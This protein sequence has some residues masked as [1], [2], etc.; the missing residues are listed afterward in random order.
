MQ[1]TRRLLSSFLLLM[2]L[3]GTFA[4]PGEWAVAGASTAGSARAQAGLSGHF[5]ALFANPAGLARL[6]QTTMGT[7]LE[8]RFA[9]AELSAA[10]AGAFGHLAV[11][12]SDRDHGCG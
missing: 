9:L 5:W 3:G 12:V 10:Q 11:L 4:Q 7:H 6:D 1:H 8:Q 2:V